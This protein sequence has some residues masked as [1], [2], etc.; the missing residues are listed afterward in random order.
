VKL[1]CHISRKFLL[2]YYGWITHNED[3]R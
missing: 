3:G 1:S 2:R